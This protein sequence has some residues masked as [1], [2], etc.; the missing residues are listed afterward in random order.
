MAKADF[1]N[2]LGFDAHIFVVNIEHLVPFGAG[3]LVGLGDKP[4]RGQK[5]RVAYK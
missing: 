2:N 1:D 3:V 5:G 4:I